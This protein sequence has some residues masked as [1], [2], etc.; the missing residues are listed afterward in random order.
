MNES[1]TIIIPVIIVWAVFVFNIIFGFNSDNRIVEHKECPTECTTRRMAEGIEYF[2]IL[3]I[4][5]SIELIGA[6]LVSISYCYNS[7]CCYLI[8]TILLFIFSILISYNYIPAHENKY[9]IFIIAKIL[10]QL[11]QMIVLI[12]Y[13]IKHD[14]SLGNSDLNKKLVN[15]LPTQGQP[16]QQEQEQE[17]EKVE[18]PV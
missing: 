13:A 18:T 6:I 14:F 8:G 4:F 17:K 7:Y 10:V 11:I 12:I 1:K 16:I 5:L 15:D 3:L 9:I 2:I